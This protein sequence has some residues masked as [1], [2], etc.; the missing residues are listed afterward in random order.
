MEPY[1]L[2]YIAFYSLLCFD[3]KC[4]FNRIMRK[5]K[6]SNHLYPSSAQFVVTV[7]V[8]DIGTYRKNFEYL[9]HDKL[10]CTPSIVYSA[11]LISL[12]EVEVSL[13]GMRVHRN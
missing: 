5:R 7:N 10:G 12:C 1:S 11:V 6:S 3:L 13:H 2:S 4:Y 8:S 9:A